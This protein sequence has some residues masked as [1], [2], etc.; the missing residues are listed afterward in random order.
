MKIY[1]TGIA[2]F[3]GSHLADY[4]LA[5]GH[6]V[7]GCDDLSTGDAENIPRGVI[8]LGCGFDID[9]LRR[10][11]FRDVDIVFHTAAAAYEGVSNFS[12]S[13]ISRNIYA[14]SAAV[15]SAAIAAGVKKIVFTSSMARYGNLVDPITN[16][17][18]LFVE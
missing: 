18:A 5:M 14:G 4:L 10:G 15:F 13:Y 16:E 9:S 11:D 8:E 3:V 2:G 1:I 17:P 7:V 12:P 6:E